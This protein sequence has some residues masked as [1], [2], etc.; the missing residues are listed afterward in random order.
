MVNTE[1]RMPVEQPIWIEKLGPGIR[2]YHYSNGEVTDVCVT[3]EP[4][5]PMD[6]GTKGTKPDGATW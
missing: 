1:M 5:G 2:R 6:M 4:N 3:D